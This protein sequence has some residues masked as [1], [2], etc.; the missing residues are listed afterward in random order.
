MAHSLASLASY[1]PAD[2]FTDTM[3][4]FTRDEMALVT[5]KGVFSY[6]Y[7]SSWEK[8]DEPQLPPQDN[9]YNILNDSHITNDD[10]EHAKAV[11]ETFGCVTLGDYSDVYLKTDVL[12]LTDVFE[13][14]RR[15][16]LQTYGLD[17]SH[18]V[19]A[20]GF[21][22]DAMLRQTGVRLEL[23][24]DYDMYM[25]VEAGIRGGVAQVIKRHCKANNICLRHTYDPSQPS[26]HVAY[27]DANNL[28]GWAMSLP[29]P[30]SGF[31]W[32]GADIDVMSIP[33]EGQTGYILEV[34]V[35]YPSALHKDHKDLP[36][37]PVSQCP[38]GSRQ[39]KLITTLES[40]ENYIIHFRN[41]KQAIQ[42]GLRL[43]KVHRVLEFK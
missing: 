31:K 22:F 37:L 39:T 42:H 43:K 20:P 33:D 14:F 28:Y 1:L 29:L 34:D 3:K 35:E 12:L 5:R 18:Y 4:F 6:D 36:F 9:F 10:Y 16:C 40:K 21:A 7:V 8:L 26:T 23:M 15:L 25:F 41:L 27:L 13:N 17:C 11:W 24:I 32:V 38:P 2:Q 30:V 19:S